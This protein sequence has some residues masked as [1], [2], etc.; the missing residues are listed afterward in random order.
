[1]IRDPVELVKDTA[2]KREDVL[3]VGVEI[4]TAARV[5]KRKRSALGSPEKVVKKK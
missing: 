3:G 1:M 4:P 2:I 5:R